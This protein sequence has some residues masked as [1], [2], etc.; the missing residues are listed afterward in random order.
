M[1]T[2]MLLKS[3]DENYWM[4]RDGKR[5]FVHR[6]GPGNSMHKTKQVDP[7]IV[8][9]AAKVCKT[10]ILEFT[11]NEFGHPQSKPEEIRKTALEY[12]RN[13]FAGRKFKNPTA[14]FPIGI[15]MGGTRHTLSFSG[16]IRKAQMLLHIDKMLEQGIYV[17]QE[18]PDPRKSRKPNVKAYHK[19]IMPVS[20]SGSPALVKITLQQDNNGH[21]FYDNKIKDIEIIK[22]VGLIQAVSNAETNAY[23]SQLQRAL[24]HTAIKLFDYNVISE[25]DLRKSR[26]LLYLLKK[27]IPLSKN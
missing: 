14:P 4:T 26:L 8:L 2:Y 20:F 23:R 15:K 11:G 25:H 12:V 6:V 21:L 9:A 13:T 24:F 27:N 1:Q 17:R 19:L 10:P 3:H 18:K 7:A 22:P 16:D 5:F